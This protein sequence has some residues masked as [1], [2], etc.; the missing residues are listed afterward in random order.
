MNLLLDMDNT[1]LYD[2]VF[3]CVDVP[4]GFT[5]WNE[6]GGRCNAY[7]VRDGAIELIE[8]AKASFDNVIIVTFSEKDRARRILFDS[9]IIELVD[10]LFAKE[11]ID[12]LRGVTFDKEFF[13]VDDFETNS[14][15]VKA[16]MQ[17]FGIDSFSE[18]RKRHVKVKK[19]F[20]VQDK[21]LFKLLKNLKIILSSF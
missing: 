16:K 3:D 7:I 18:M 15:L 20:G 12:A 5:I 2:D 6:T 9:G 10:D 8:W 13:L 14:F 11:D 1:L 17:C 19:F 4:N 21:T